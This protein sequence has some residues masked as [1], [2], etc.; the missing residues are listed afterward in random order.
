[1][2]APSA[3]LPAHAV[4]DDSSRTFR[5]W[6]TRTLIAT[7]FG[8]AAFYFVRKNLSI[9]MPAMQ[10]DL[11]ITK[12][13]L[14]LFLTLHGVLYGVSKFVN[15]P[16]ADRSNARYFMVAGLMLSVV[17]NVVF[18]FSST[19]LILGV[20][21]MFNGWVQG[22]GFPPCCRLMTHWFPPDKLATK[23]SIWNTS[24]SIGAWVAV[25]F[26]GY[27]VGFGWRWCFFA[28]AI[29]CTAAGVIL[30]ILLRDTPSSVGLPEI[31]VAGA[32]S[33]YHEDRSSADYRA[34]VRKHVFGNPTI[35]LISFANFFV[36]ILRFAVL[37]WGP[38]LLKEMKGFSLQNAG[39]MVAG[40]E[41]AGLIGMLLAGW[42]TDR[43]FA[44]RGSRTCVFCM[45]GAVAAMFAFWKLPTPSP[46]AAALL[47]GTAGF[48]IYGPQALIG[49]TAAN[50]ATKRA[51]ATAAGLTGLF[52]YLSTVVSGWGLGLLVQHA[53]W[54]VA[55]G[56]LL[57]VGALG[58]FMFLLA[59]SSKA[60]G[61]SDAA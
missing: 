20:A 13:D 8:Y 14:G 17:A 50:L 25:V 59:W 5:Y 39:W 33:D 16:V 34:F 11:H 6:Q 32:A 1:M 47:L 24:H 53:G 45:I 15:G 30:F 38:T 3:P 54:D 28:P 7:M 29:L 4:V 9:A 36:Y 10:D 46:V 2:N 51:S 37:D 42:I 26:C 18:G 60:H 43:V 31:K 27:I 56:A 19:V 40:F 22:M 35:W 55:F 41:A 58:T 49:I 52:G 44:G 61:Y 21:W 48:F 57:A 12:A 23:M